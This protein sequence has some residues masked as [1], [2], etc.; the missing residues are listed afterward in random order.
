MRRGLPL[1]FLVI[2]VASV[3]LFAMPQKYVD[4]GYKLIWSDEFSGTAVDTTAW[5]FIEACN[6]PNQEQEFYTKSCLTVENGNLVVW[7]KYNPN[8]QQWNAPN[9]AAARYTSGRIES[10]KKKQFTFGYFETKLI[11]PVGQVPG[12]G[13]WS[14]V[15]TLGAGIDDPKVGWPACGEMELYEQRCGDIIFTPNAPQLSAATYGDNE[16]V[17]TC[18]FKGGDGGVNLNSQMVTSPTPYNTKYHTFG[19][20]WDSS[21]VEYYVDDSLYWGPNF[22]TKGYSTPSITQPS[23]FAAFHGPQFWIIN[24]AIGGAYQGQNIKNAIFPTK[25]LVDYVRVY[26]KTTSVRNGI[27]NS[28]KQPVENFSLVNP[29][30]AQLKVFNL[31]GNLIADYSGKVRT[32]RTGDNALK[33][34][35]S[36]MSNGVYVVRLFDNG[37]CFSQKFMTT[38]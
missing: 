8:G 31:Q 14:A 35:P 6:Q 22:P 12:P 9:A 38:K 26:Q 25:M 17:G 28:A 20:L 10:R 30:S 23:N 2:L 29:S 36:A 21:H 13:L 34:L 37:K 1:A 16:F 7:S 32:L 3:G 33:A 24:V 4:G 19:I 5:S 15:W 27:E 11:T 18:H